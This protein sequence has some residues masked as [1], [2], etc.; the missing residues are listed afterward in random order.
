MLNYISYYLIFGKPLMMYLGITTFS[1]LVTTATLG[2][3]IKSGRNIN[4]KVH[5][6]FA[7][8]TIIVAIIHGTLGILAYF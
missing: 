4:I 8:T 7:I 5:L 3:L 1:L 6:G 2:Y